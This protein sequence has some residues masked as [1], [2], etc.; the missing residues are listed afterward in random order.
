MSAECRSKGPASRRNRQVLPRST[1]QPNRTTAGSSFPSLSAGTSYQL[2]ATVPSP[3]TATAGRDGCARSLTT[4][5]GWLHVRPP[6]SERTTAT[7]AAA[8]GRGTDQH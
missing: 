2:T 5:I 1:D 3:A 4:V 6:S 7:T 8:D